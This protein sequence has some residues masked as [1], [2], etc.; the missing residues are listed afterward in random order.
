MSA[1]VESDDSVLRFPNPGSDIDGFIRIFHELFDA[2]EARQTFGL[3][4]MSRVL[5]ERNLATSSGFM[6]AAALERSYRA[7][8]SRDALYNQSKMYSELYKALGWIH[9]TVGSAL[10]FKFT[11]LGAHA[12]NARRDPRALMEECLLGIVFPNAVLQV[13]TDGETRPFATILRSMEALDGMLCRDEMILGPLCLLN[14]RDDKRFEAMIAEILALRGS[15]A[16]LEEA[17]QG[18][19]RT[20]GITTNTMGNYTRFPLAALEWAGWVDVTTRRDIYGRALKFRAL[21][22]KGYGIVKRTGQ[23]LDLRGADLKDTGDELK[24]AAV[25][26]GFFDTLE[27]AGFDTSPQ[28]G[29][30]KSDR[31]LVAR[32]YPA[33]SGGMLFSPF[34]DLPLSYLLGVFPDVSGASAASGGIEVRE[35]TDLAVGRVS[36]VVAVRSG[37]PIVSHGDEVEKLLKEAVASA[38][39]IP[40]A[41]SSLVERY[42][43]ANKAEYY[44]LVA[45]LFTA[46]GYRCET[47]RVGVHYQRYDAI[48]ID[49]QE[50]VPLEIK[51]PGEEEFLSVKG[52]RQAL[53][54]KVVLLARKPYPT[55]RETTSLAVGF[56]L[57]ADRSEVAGLVADIRSVFAITIGVFDLRTLFHL[58]AAAV[59]QGKTHDR[60]ALMRLYG[61]AEISDT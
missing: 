50:S 7:D 9:P 12:A 52:I 5:V 44:P 36:S 61:I 39:S 1:T 30:L 20:R 49:D 19:S 53:E 10:T 42:A 15:F 29:Q 46:L 14:D 8:R 21:T 43:R 38:G 45:R 51:S 59:L 17:L 58:V 57:P 22:P 6:G 25:R 2:L 4:D 3:D 33:A 40:L 60:E 13:A 32:R 55:R 18:L 24:K 27:R 23:L 48:I 34:Q 37:A 47:S 11:F 26:V 31:G 54:N 41:I 16:R 56:R 35:K 28:A